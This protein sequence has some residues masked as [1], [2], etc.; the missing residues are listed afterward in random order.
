MPYRFLADALVVFHLGFVLFVLFGGLLLLRWPRAVWLHLPAVAWGMLVEWTGW[1]CPLTPLEV[2]LRQ[3]GG[4]EGYEGGFV[5]H[6]I[7]PLLYTEDLL[8][9]Y[10]IGFR[11][12][13][14]ILGC[15]VLVLNLAVY[16]I[17]ARRAYVKRKRRRTE[18]AAP[19]GN[20][21][22]VPPQPQ[23]PSPNVA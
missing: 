9:R 10:E 8:A 19:A 5:D 3:W 6:Y 23:A 16:G 14:V 15:V 2:K 12:F 13:Q 7:V 1:L 4:G 22:T 21:Q 18:N 20:G 17:V 11:T